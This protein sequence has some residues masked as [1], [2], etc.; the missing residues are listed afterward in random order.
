MEFLGREYVV[1]PKRPRVFREAPAVQQAMKS[2]G[3]PDTTVAEILSSDN[4]EAI[5]KL[6]PF[7]VEIQYFGLPTDKQK[8]PNCLKDGKALS[9]LVKVGPAAV[10]LLLQ[11]YQANA[12]D[13]MSLLNALVVCDP[14]LQAVL[15]WGEGAKADELFKI[16][17]MNSL[18]ILLLAH[19]VPRGSALILKGLADESPIGERLYPVQENSLLSQTNKVEINMGKPYYRVVHRNCDELRE[20]MEDGMTFMPRLHRYITNETELDQAV[21]HLRTWLS[22]ES[23][24]GGILTRVCWFRPLLVDREGKPFVADGELQFMVFRKGGSTSTF[25]VP[26]WLPFLPTANQPAPQVKV[27]FNEKSQGTR[28]VFLAPASTNLIPGISVLELRLTESK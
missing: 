9:N 12:Y 5:R 4:E 18:P 17:V 14:D 7:L 21:A 13:A 16:A 19:D 11:C 3:L 6:I 23:K 26:S 27:Y 2:L 15:A 8:V 20:E 10:P 28:H 25:S 1:A 22:A 24:P